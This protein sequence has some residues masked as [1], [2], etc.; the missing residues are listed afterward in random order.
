MEGRPDW[1]RTITCQP[2][3]DQ[4]FPF[5]LSIAYIVAVQVSLYYYAI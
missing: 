2:K 1:L 4:S 5:S 3:F